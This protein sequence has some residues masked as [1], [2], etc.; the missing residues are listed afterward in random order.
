MNSKLQNQIGDQFAAMLTVKTIDHITT[1][2]L[3]PMA[4][5]CTGLRK[6]R[7]PNTLS[8]VCMAGESR[9]RCCSP[10]WFFRIRLLFGAASNSPPQH[11][12]D[13]IKAVS[14]SWNKPFS[15]SCRTTRRRGL[16]CIAFVERV[17]CRAVPRDERDSQTCRSCAQPG[18]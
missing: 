15:F 18:S 16:R 17:R 9:T 8:Y 13:G 4:C 10:N 7:L 3:L 1:W 12:A 6:D 11:C 2:R 5:I 14:A